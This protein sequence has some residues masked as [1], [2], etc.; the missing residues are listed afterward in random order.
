MRFDDLANFLIFI[1]VAIMWLIGILSTAKRLPKTPLPQKK[2]REP[3]GYT[4]DSAYRKP[5]KRIFKKGLEEL[6]SLISQKAAEEAALPLE[7]E[8]LQPALIESEETRELDLDID[9]LREGILLSA[10]LGPPKSR[11][12]LSFYRKVK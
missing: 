1:F 11:E 4:V 5:E 6:T 7:E 8:I 3:E 9:K 10:I 12:P 2:K